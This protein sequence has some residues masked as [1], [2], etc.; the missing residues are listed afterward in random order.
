M[1]KHLVIENYAL[2]ES[3]S[4][5]FEKGFTVITGET[6]AGKSIMLGALHL[7]LGQRADTQTLFDPSQ[8]C[9]V[10]GSFAIE[11]LGLKDFFEQNDLDYDDTAIL[12]REIAPTGKSRAFI[13]DTPASL[14]VLKDLG[15][16]IID[17][18][19]Q[20]QTL[21]INNSSFQLQLLD[22]LSNHPENLAAY[23]E[24]YTSHT[25]LKQ[26]LEQLKAEDAK[27]KLDLD[28]YQ[29]QFDELHAANL[30]EDEQDELE[31][32]LQ[33]MN[34]TEVLKQTLSAG[35]EILDEGEHA[36]TP[37]LNTLKNM[38]SKIAGIDS[39]FD[40]LSRR[41]DSV[42]IELK[43]VAG[44]FSSL[45]ERTNFSREE[46]DEIALRLDTLYRLQNKHNVKSSKELIDIRNMLDEKLNSVTNLEEKI[47]QQDKATAEAQ[48]QLHAT[49]SELTAHRQ[50]AA[51]ALENQI[52]PTLQQLS[53]K[54]AELKIEI[55]PLAEPSKSGFDEAVFLF[56]A[57]KGS[58]FREIEKV[59]SG[60]ELSR[61]MLAIKSLITRNTLLPTIIFDEIDSGVSGGIASQVGNIMLSM[62]DKMQV[63][64]ITHLPQIAAKGSSHFKVFKSIV[65]NRTI[66]VIKPL[67]K[68]EKLEE[69]AQMLSSGKTTESA[70]Q[71]ARELME[72]DLGG[73]I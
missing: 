52:L 4:I 5:D 50:K 27:N 69:I 42:C 18:H 21:T 19:S 33:V 58:E 39:G 55:T 13:N 40:D 29:F 46:Q 25:R 20:H 59:A 65:G 22:M 1:L 45:E 9:I 67:N 30:K 32:R 63:I 2:I 31:Q 62:S 35:V 34:H 73:K 70:L 17:I 10:E 56:K 3:L 60:G 54:D 37:Q 47:K 11:G 64:A 53:M 6:G 12:R 26:Q 68:Q 41:I 36:V 72:I 14:Q 71:M 24:A 38:L 15:G 66:S 57:N 61:L 48:K 8:K 43:D 49:A 44:E 23:K 16:K 51:K 7:I 28:Y